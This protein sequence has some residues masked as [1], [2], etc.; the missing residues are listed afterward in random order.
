ML[1]NDL[2]IHHRKLLGIIVDQRKPCF[3]GYVKD[4]NTCGV[5]VKFLS[6]K[7]SSQSGSSQLRSNE[8]GFWITLW[9]NRVGK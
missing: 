7:I 9:L 5:G 3:R 4:I 6:V 2:M 1:H 8:F